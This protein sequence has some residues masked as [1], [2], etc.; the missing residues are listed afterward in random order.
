[1]LHIDLSLYL[2]ELEIIVD[3]QPMYAGSLQMGWHLTL[4]H[5]PVPPVCAVSYNELLTL[6]WDRIDPTTLNRQGNDRGTQYRSG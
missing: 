4:S 1:M 6:F 5:P 2:S 3:L